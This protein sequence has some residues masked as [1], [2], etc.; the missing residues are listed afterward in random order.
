[1]FYAGDTRTILI[2]STTAN[3][4][5][6]DAGVSSTWSMVFIWTGTPTAT[7]KVQV[8]PDKSTWTDLPGSSQATGGTEGSHTVN[9]SGSGHRYLRASYD[10]SSGAGDLTVKWTGKQ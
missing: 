5:P 9:Y 1:V 3:S 4:E 8:S 7:V 10:L 6:V 2:T